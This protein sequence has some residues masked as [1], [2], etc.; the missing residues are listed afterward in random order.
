M[1]EVLS[2]V[3]I[4]LS[5]IQAAEPKEA[6]ASRL[7]ER[8]VSRRGFHVSSDFPKTPVAVPDHFHFAENVAEICRKSG[9]SVLPLGQKG[10]PSDDPE[11]G[12]LPGA[13][14]AGDGELLLVFRK[15]VR[16]SRV[17]SEAELHFELIASRN[18]PVHGYD[19]HLELMH[20][21]GGGWELGN[22]HRGAWKIASLSVRR[23]PVTVRVYGAR[24]SAEALEDVKLKFY[25]KQRG[26]RD[27]DEAEFTFKKI[28]F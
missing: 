3:L 13:Q 18:V 16:D 28:P 23:L 25:F 6:P 22:R 24:P 20:G 11:F 15:S 21:F 9:C 26:L 10:R 8:L 19:P 27:S 14:I 5:A 12:P 17:R 4:A 1:L 2:G 7:I